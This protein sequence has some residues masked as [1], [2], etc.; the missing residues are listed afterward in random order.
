MGRQRRRRDAGATKRGAT[1]SGITEIAHPRPAA[2]A[3]LLRI[4]FDVFGEFEEIGLVADQMV[5]IFA[6]PENTSATEGRVCT[7]SGIGLPGVEDRGKSE[8]R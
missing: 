1:K 4:L 5:E 3:C 8:F 7:M 2:W 6:L